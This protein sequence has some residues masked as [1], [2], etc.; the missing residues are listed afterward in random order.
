MHRR[1]DCKGKVVLVVDDIMTT[2]ATGNETARI[3]YAAG[4]QKVYFITAVATPE[5]K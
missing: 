4:A 2:G 1:K 5:K 3:L